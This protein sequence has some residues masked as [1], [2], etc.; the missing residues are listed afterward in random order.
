VPETG[1]IKK[2]RARFYLL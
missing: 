1:E 2:V